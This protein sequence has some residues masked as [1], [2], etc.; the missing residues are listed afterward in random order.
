[1]LYG[2]IYEWETR[3]PPSVGTWGGVGGGGHPT[4]L[5][6]QKTFFTCDRRCIILRVL[7]AENFFCIENLL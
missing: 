5:F 2:I 6:A 3:K 1:M 7:R 4:K